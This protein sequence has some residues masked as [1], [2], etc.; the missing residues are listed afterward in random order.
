M[1][2][3]FLRSALSVLLLVQ[4]RVLAE[5]ASR[6]L[7]ALRPLHTEMTG[8]LTAHLAAKNP[9]NPMPQPGETEAV[10]LLDQLF[11]GASQLEASIRDGLLDGDDEP[12]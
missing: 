1:N 7:I 2:E 11:H 9:N 3:E 5:L 12:H 8:N 6:D 10:A 4:E